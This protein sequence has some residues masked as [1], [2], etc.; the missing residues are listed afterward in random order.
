MRILLIYHVGIWASE[1]RLFNKAKRKHRIDAIDASSIV[2]KKDQ[3]GL[4][5]RAGKRNILDWDAV[6]IFTN[7]AKLPLA[8]TVASFLKR[9]KKIVLN[10]A[11]VKG[12]VPSNKLQFLDRTQA[13]KIPHPKTYSLGLKKDIPPVLK[14]LGLPVII[15]KATTIHGTGVRLFR[16]R[17]QIIKFFKKN[18]LSDYIWQ[19][20]IPVKEDTRVI[21]VNYKAIGAMSRHAPPGD[22]RTN[23]RKGGYATPKDLLP[24]LKRLAEK[25][26]RAV[27]AEM[28]GVDILTHRGRRYVLEV[29]HYP[30]FTGFYKATGINMAE[31]II[32][33]IE[34]K[35]KKKK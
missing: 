26:A 16:N 6:C 31:H 13:L 4:S 8:F 17:K 29:N 1:V 11:F 10:S 34:Q 27:Q 35:A 14:D 2:V 18:E 23:I 7:S 30:G 20:Y 22:F 19:K 28:A 25:S 33:Y 21:C 3:Q 15:K 5:I 12:T 24:D 9:H 32:K